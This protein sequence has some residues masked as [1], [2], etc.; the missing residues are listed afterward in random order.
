MMMMMT[1]ILNSHAPERISLLDRT[2]CYKWHAIIVLCSPLKDSVPMDCNFHALHVVFNVDNNTIV[3]A[4]LDA[5]PRNHSVGGQN[6][7]LNTIC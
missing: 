6:S 1:M 2:L 5:W 7:T 3:L 4:D